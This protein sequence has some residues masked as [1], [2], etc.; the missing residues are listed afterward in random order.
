MSCLWRGILLGVY[1]KVLK[2]NEMCRLF[3]VLKLRNITAPQHVYGTQRC[4]S[5][6]ERDEVMG[7]KHEEPHGR[8]TL[9]NLFKRIWRQECST[10]LSLYYLVMS[11]LV[12]NKH[13]HS[14]TINNIHNQFITIHLLLGGIHQLI[15]FHT[16][17]HRSTQVFAECQ[18]DTSWWI[19]EAWW[20][21]WADWCS[22]HLGHLV[23]HVC[24]SWLTG[25]TRLGIRDLFCHKTI[26][27]KW[28]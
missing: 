7:K 12:G 14:T 23:C 17:F 10:L 1:D 3:V 25:W 4:W 20:D 11:I 9:L 19:F 22:Y 15:S 27:A 16:T 13:Q 5:W 21:W 6:I 26:G 24:L 8:P 28:L 2:C 18:R